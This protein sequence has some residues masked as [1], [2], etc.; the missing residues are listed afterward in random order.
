MQLLLIVSRYFLRKLKKVKKTNGQDACRQVL[1]WQLHF[2]VQFHTVL[3]VIVLLSIL[4]VDFREEPR[5]TVPEPNRVR[6]HVQEVP[7]GSL[8]FRSLR[9]PLS[10][11]VSATE[12][13]PSSSI[14][15]R[16]SSL[17]FSGRSDH[18]IG[19]SRL[20]TRLQSQPFHVKP[21]FAW[22]S[23]HPCQPGIRL[24]FLF[25]SL[26]KFYKFSIFKTFAILI[27]YE[28]SKSGCFREVF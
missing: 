1:V 8:A 3:D 20:H 23:T 14:S 16:S 2:T 17:L 18:Q 7:W 19:S 21:V 28:Y 6:Q 13:A 25:P 26:F 10:L 15:P 24:V 5:T 9:P 22:F 27:W 11:Q 12:R 4:F